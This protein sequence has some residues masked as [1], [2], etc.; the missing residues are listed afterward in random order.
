MSKGKKKQKTDNSID[1]WSRNQFESR[2][3]TID[4][5]LGMSPQ[6]QPTASQQSYGRYGMR[7]TGSR[8]IDFGQPMIEAGP[9][10]PQRYGFQGDLGTTGLSD[11]ETQ[12]GDLINQYV[13]GYGDQLGNIRGMVNDANLDFSDSRGLI[14]NT[15]FTPGTLTPQTFA[16]FNADV[17]VNPYADD[18][19]SRTTGDIEEAAARQRNQ[20][21]ANNLAQNAFGGARHGVSDALTNEAMLDSIGDMA[22]QTRFNV[23]DRGADR[24]YQDVGNDMYA[25]QYNNDQ[26]NQGAAFDLQRAAM[27]SDLTSR[28]GAFDLERAGMLSD[29]VGQ[30]RGFQDQDISRLMGIGGLERSIT[31]AAAAREYDNYWRTIQAQM[32]LLGSVPII[33]DGETTQTTR[34]G[35]LG[36]AG[37]LTSGISTLFNPVDGVFG[38]G[39]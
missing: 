25:Q 30:E 6:P 28:E 8:G 15:S 21:S 10:Q 14:N 12:A 24:F 34:P 19:I 23:W 9:A 26:V 32:G 37:A 31:D 35:L 36:T 11:Y 39:S 7:P 22:A 27:L 29:L 17:Y 38:Q 33:Q 18:I 16:D 4:G 5:M 20:T 2:Q 3:R 13:G 1:P